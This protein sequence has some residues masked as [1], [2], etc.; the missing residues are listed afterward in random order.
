VAT[1]PAKRRRHRHG[2]YFNRSP[3][4]GYRGLDNFMLRTCGNSNGWD[5]CANLKYDVTVH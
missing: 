2:G 3:K 1:C 5:G 4:A